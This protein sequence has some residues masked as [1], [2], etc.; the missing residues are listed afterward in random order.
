VPHLEVTLLD[1]D[2]QPVADGEVGEICVRPRAPGLIFCGYFHDPQ[3]TVASWRTLWHHTGD[4]A[5]KDSD[6]LY[7]FADRKQDYIRYKGRNLS[8]FEVEAV[9]ANHPAVA[10]VAAYGIA[11]GELESE[12]ELMIAVV[13]KPNACLA[14]EQLA[15]YINAEAP[16][17]FVPRY[18]LFVTQLERNRHGRLVKGELKARGVTADTWD[19]VRS[20]FEVKRP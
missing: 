12:S 2:D 7:R 13:L 10:D 17:Y 5:F 18:I 16:H 14:H 8:M 9:V 6:G 4:M 3:R 11:S 19:R 15:D 20:G 1:A